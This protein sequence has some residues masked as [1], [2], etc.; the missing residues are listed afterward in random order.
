VHSGSFFLHSN[1]LPK[2]HFFIAFTAVCFS[3]NYQEIRHTIWQGILMHELAMAQEIVSTVT[4]ILKQHP[5]KVVRKVHLKVGELAAVVPD[6]LK[7]SYDSIIPN[8]PLQNSTLK[9]EIVPISAIC[10]KCEKTFSIDE[11]DFCCPNCGSQDVNVQTGNELL[12]SNLE[13]E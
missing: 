3:F 6:S 12:I 9:I 7:F 11:M 10:N 1:I 2:T 13:V 4:E 5:G 8:T